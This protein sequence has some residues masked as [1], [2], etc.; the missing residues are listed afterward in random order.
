M[1]ISISL[2]DNKMTITFKWT[3]IE[4]AL[5]NDGMKVLAIYRSKEGMT[6]NCAYRGWFRDII[7]DCS[8][9]KGKFIMEMD[10]PELPATHW[11]PSIDLPKE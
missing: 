1:K 6:Y 10:G 7:Y 5:P 9:E 4:E 11:M 2:S 3:S 8:F